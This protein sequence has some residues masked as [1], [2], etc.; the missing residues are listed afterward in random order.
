[1]LYS[2]II[3]CV[4]CGAEIEMPPVRHPDEAIRDGEH[5]IVCEKCYEAGT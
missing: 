1:M 2:F 5:Q 4:E 3:H